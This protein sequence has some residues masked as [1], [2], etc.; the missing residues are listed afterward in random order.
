MDGDRTYRVTEEVVGLGTYG[1][2]LTILTC[3]ALSLRPETDENDEEEE[4]N[5]I[6][7][8]TLRFRK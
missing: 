2:T 4:R 7:S 1:R 8:W 5:L 3:A 6:D